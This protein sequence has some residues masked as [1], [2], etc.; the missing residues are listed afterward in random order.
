MQ[1]DST[2]LK[3]SSLNVEN[4]PRDE[5]MLGAKSDDMSLPKKDLSAI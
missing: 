2:L 5:K 3:I 1:K 4:Q